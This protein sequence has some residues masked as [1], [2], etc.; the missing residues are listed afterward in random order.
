MRKLLITLCFLSSSFAFAAP[1]W[2]EYLIEVE[3]PQSAAKVVA[4]TDKFMESDFVKENF[5]GS[6]HLNAIIAAGKAEETH[7]YAVLQ[8]SLAEHE[9]WLAKLSDPNNQEA[10]KFLSVLNANSSDVGTRINTF[11]QTYGTP[12]N[13]DTVW[14]VYPFRTKPSNVE[15]I[16]EATEDLD[17]AIKDTFPGQFGLS[18]RMSGGGMQTHLY[19]VGYESMAEM[20]AWEDSSVR[21]EGVSPFDRVMDKLVDWQDS[22]LVRNIRV[23]ETA[24]TLTDFVESNK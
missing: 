3:D 14:A 17:K 21:N 22:E 13:K 10:Q 23:Y 9:I 11:I 12:S 18:A 7:S 15:D 5:K 16:V 24:A 1:T 20:E 2:I 6:L 19:T 8:P 4:A